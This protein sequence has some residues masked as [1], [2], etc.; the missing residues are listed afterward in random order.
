VTHPDRRT[1]VAT[2]FNAGKMVQKITATLSTD[3]KHRTAAAEQTDK[4]GELLHATVVWN[5]K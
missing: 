1:E 4:E 5:K 3:G 2:F